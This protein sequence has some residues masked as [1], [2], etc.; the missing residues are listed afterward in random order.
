ML[1]VLLEQ[2]SNNITPEENIRQVVLLA[3]TY[4]HAIAPVASAHPLN[5][6]TCLMHVLG[7]TGQRSYIDSVGV[8]P[9]EVFAGAKFAEWLFRSG[10]LE[11]VPFANAVNGELVWYFAS[12][13]SFKHAGLLRGHGR[14]ES[15]WGDL[16][17]FEHLLF[18]IPESYGATVRLFKPLP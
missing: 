15:K 10:A 17:L 5:S 6:Y 11:E 9:C 12:D 18:E 2:V 8:P 16:G 7:F 13:G 14:I 3:Q 4:P 1:R